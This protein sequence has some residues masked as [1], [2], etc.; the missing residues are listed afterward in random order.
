MAM[1]QA[2]NVSASTV[3][4]ENDLN[5]R[6]EQEAIKKENETKAQLQNLAQL[7][8]AEVQGQ[9]QVIAAKYQ[10]L[11][12]I[13]S[14]KI[15]GIAQNQEAMK[16]QAQGGKPGAPGQAPGQVPGQAP[17]QAQPSGGPPDQAEADQMAGQQAQQQQM[18][19]P[20]LVE[21][22]A[23]QIM[24]MAPEQQEMI[25]QRMESQQDGA[26][27]Q[28]AAAIREYM[29]KVQKPTT[30]MRPLPEQKPPRRKAALV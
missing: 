6:E 8:M 2:G 3:L 22:Y 19:L 14:Q 16:N 1:Q 24:G 4:S 17:G 12:Q 7:Q 29:A 25:L 15:M 9:L 23:K 30:D 20:Q 18:A 13:E 26:M 28:L 21:S 27:P 11:A 10:A 5:F